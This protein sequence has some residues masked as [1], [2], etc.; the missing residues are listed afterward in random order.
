MEDK[1]CKICAN[2][3]KCDWEDMKNHLYNLRDGTSDCFKLNV[4]LI[5]EVMKHL[6]NKKNIVLRCSYEKVKS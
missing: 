2:Y 6:S 5:E 3:G 1:D 4:E